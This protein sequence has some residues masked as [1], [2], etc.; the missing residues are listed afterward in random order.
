MNISAEFRILIASIFIMVTAAANAESVEVKYRGS[1]D[2]SHFQCD[3]ITRSSFIKHVCYD[4][5]NQYMLIQLK[6][7]YYHYCGIDADTVESLNAANS[8][9]RFYNQ[10]IKGNYD[11]RIGY[12]PGYD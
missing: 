7:T 4:A 3:E 9:G 10:K 6:R 12:V 1:V 8:M 5:D 11:C 2:L